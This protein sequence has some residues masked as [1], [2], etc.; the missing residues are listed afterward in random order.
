VRGPNLPVPRSDG[1][2]VPREWPPV[3]PVPRPFWHA[4]GT[5]GRTL[6]AGAPSCPRQ[7]CMRPKLSD[8]KLTRTAGSASD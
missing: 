5:G 6:R 1:A 8:G 4:S 7:I 2:A 3:T